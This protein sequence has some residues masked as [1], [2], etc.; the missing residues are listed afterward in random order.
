[1]LNLECCSLLLTRQKYY[2]DYAILQQT[3]QKNKDFFLVILTLFNLSA[4]NEFCLC[5]AL[6]YT[7]INIV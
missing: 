4:W 7:P 2:S 5:L 1:M 6:D 3:Y